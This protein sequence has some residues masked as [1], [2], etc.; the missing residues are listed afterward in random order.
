M[1]T[2]TSEKIVSFV[3]GYG[4]PES[5][6]VTREETIVNG[7]YIASWLMQFKL[8]FKFKTLGVTGVECWGISRV[9]IDHITC[10]RS[11]ANAKP[12]DLQIVYAG[13]LLSGVEPEKLGWIAQYI[14]SKL[15]RP[16]LRDRLCKYKEDYALRTLKRLRRIVE[17]RIP[18]ETA[19]LLV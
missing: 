11:L 9:I 14:Y 13:R 6:K 10:V 19:V 3:E 18:L 16:Q 7:I 15:Y 4:L 8:P 2:S 5:E 17:L 12:A 1:K